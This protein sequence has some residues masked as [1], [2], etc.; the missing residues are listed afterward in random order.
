MSEKRKMVSKKTRFQATLERRQPHRTL[1]KSF[2]VEDQYYKGTEVGTA[3]KVRDLYR[4]Y[5]TSEAHRGYPF[6]KA[7]SVSG[8]MSKYG[9]RLSLPSFLA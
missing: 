1:R 3:R 2:L 4:T 8:K 6:W 5:V 9:P 7:N